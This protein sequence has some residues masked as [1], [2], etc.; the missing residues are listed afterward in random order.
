MPG[1]F[2]IELAVVL[3]HIRGLELPVLQNPLALV[4]QSPRKRL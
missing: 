2:A 4:P 3:R 1:P